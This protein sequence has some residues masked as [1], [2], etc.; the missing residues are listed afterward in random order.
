M[1]VE[2][3]EVVVDGCRWLLVVLGGFR[4]FLVLVLTLSQAN[5]YRLDIGAGCTTECL[6]VF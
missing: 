1:V 4:S 3:F 6:K 5:I 2:I